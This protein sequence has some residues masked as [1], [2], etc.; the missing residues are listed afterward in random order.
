MRTLP[1]YYW[2]LF[3][4]L[5]VVT[6]CRPG[7]SPDVVG[8]LP[9]QSSSPPETLTPEPWVGDPHEKWPQ[10]LLT[11]KATVPDH[12]AWEGACAFLIERRDGKVLAATARHLLGPLQA[13]DIATV[14]LPWVLFPRTQEK[15]SIQVDQIESA[16]YDLMLLSLKEGE[17]P[18]VPL[19]VRNEPVREG[20]WVYVIGCNLS[21]KQVP[22]KVY[23]GKVLA[24]PFGPRFEFSIAPPV[25]LF[26]FSGSPVI[27]NWGHAVGVVAEAGKTN[28]DGKNVTG[29]AMEL[30]AVCSQPEPEGSFTLDEPATEKVKRTI[31]E[32]KRAPA[33]LRLGFKPNA[34]TDYALDLDSVTGKDDWTGESNGVKIVVE[35]KDLPRLRGAFIGYSSDQNGFFI[36]APNHYRRQP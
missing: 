31:K 26:G 10:L 8:P 5:L 6:G 1:T 35:K 19:K 9:T 7:A 20:E 21:Q 18:V 17:L 34:P 28:E 12:P 30:R 29:T 16:S 27:D 2:G 14:K 13:K 24:A 11:N 36:T 22:Q 15:R 4:A 33:Y 25:T 23:K 32:Q 3:V